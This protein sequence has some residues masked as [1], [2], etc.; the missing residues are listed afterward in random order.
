MPFA[1]RPR[2]PP[3]RMPAH[4][5][6]REGFEIVFIAARA[7]GYRVSGRGCADRGGRGVGGGVRDRARSPRGSRGARASAAARRAASASWRST[8]T[9][10]RLACQRRARPR[11]RREPGRQPRGVA[12]A[13]A[14][15]VHRLALAVGASAEAPAAYVRAVDLRVERLERRYER[16][17]TWTGAAST[18]CR[19]RSFPVRATSTTSTGRA[20]LPGHRRPRRLSVRRGT[21]TRGR[22]MGEA[23][24]S[25]T[26]PIRSRTSGASRATQRGAAATASPPPGPNRAAAQAARRNAAFA[27]YARASR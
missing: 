22:A 25:P 7:D 11:A 21:L 14:L 26:V 1:A 5:E 13:N 19:L 18:T 10:G 15:P 24:R 17:P 2:R 9:A 23:R 12:F 16:T 20:R 8:R 6:A 27:R 4:V 3:R